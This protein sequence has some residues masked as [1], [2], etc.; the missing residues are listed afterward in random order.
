MKDSPFYVVK[1]IDVPKLWREI[2][3]HYSSRSESIS[4]V[5]QIFYDAFDWRLFRK[6]MTLIREENDLYLTDVE[7]LEP[8]LIISWP[9]KIQPKFWW[10]FPEGP[11]KDALKPLLDVR[12]LMS[13]TT[14]QKKRRTLSILN[15]DEKAVVKVH[16]DQ[17]HLK[18][19]SQKVRNIHSFVLQPIR[20]Y[21]KD[22]NNFRQFLKE[23]YVVESEECI[24]LRVLRAVGKT[25]GDYT[26]KFMLDLTPDLHSHQA[27]RMI[28]RYLI[29]VMKSN[30]RGI[31]ADTD[32]EF[33]HDF[34]VSSRRIRSALGQIRGVRRR[35]N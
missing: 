7:T 33:L 30:E 3:Q 26:S 21:R 2:R 23:R 9:K 1:L 29:D 10:Q 4:V 14:I 6:K 20:G 31:K 27:M 35:T 11:M 8:S 34:R 15:K 25:P 22:L 13:L 5:T 28:L 19:S 16:H 18:D 12:A 17:I 32:T 24:Y